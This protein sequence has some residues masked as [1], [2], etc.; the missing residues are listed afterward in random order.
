MGPGMIYRVMHQ[1]KLYNI[2]KRSKEAQ[3]IYIIL[4][5]VITLMKMNQSM[6]MICKYFLWNKILFS[7]FNFSVNWY[8]PC[9]SI[10]LINLN[11]PC[12]KQKTNNKKQL[13]EIFLCFI[14]LVGFILTQFDFCD[15]VHFLFNQIH[16][17]RV[18]ENEAHMDRHNSLAGKLNTSQYAFDHKLLFICMMYLFGPLKCCFHFSD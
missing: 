8:L 4:S 2:K 13:T 3:R 7:L 5:M 1:N 17:W 18:W 12:I 10:F 14:Y 6:K 9:F 16:S 11:L 15:I